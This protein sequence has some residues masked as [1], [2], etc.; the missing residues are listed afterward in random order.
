MSLEAVCSRRRFAGLIADSLNRYV[1]VWIAAPRLVQ[2]ETQVLAW[3]AELMGYPATTRGLLTTG[4]SMANLT[5][6]VTRAS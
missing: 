5:A 3:L 2:I 1:G 6:I 4:G